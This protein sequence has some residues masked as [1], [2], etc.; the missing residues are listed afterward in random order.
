MTQDEILQKLTPIFRD[1]FD[2]PTLVINLATTADD[3]EGWDSVS[4]TRPVTVP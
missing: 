2:A 4:T 3:V 1:V